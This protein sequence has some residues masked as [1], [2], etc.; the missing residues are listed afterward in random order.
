[1]NAECDRPS[2]GHLIIVC[3]ADIFALVLHSHP[4]QD[5]Y[6]V[7]VGHDGALWDV[8]VLPG[9]VV[10]G[11]GV[12][13]GDA[14]KPHV[15]A[16]HGGLREGL[17]E[18]LG[19]PELLVVGVRG[20]LELE[21]GAVPA[22]VGNRALDGATVVALVDLLEGGEVD[23][24]VV[25]DHD[26]TVLIDEVGKV[27]PGPVELDVGEVLG[28]VARNGLA[29]IFRADLFAPPKNEL[30]NEAEGDGYGPRP[31]GAEFIRSGAEVLAPVGHLVRIVD[32]QLA[33]ANSDSFIFERVNFIR[34]KSIILESLLEPPVSRGGPSGGDAE[35]AYVVDHL[36][37]AHVEHGLIGLPDEEGSHGVEPGVSNGLAVLMST[38]VCHEVSNLLDGHL[39]DE[40][41][42]LV[43]EDGLEAPPLLL[44]AIR[45]HQVVLLVVREAVLS[46]LVGL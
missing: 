21:E 38:L 6:P 18:V 20:D 25:R 3:S 42:L 28:R 8:R 11:H 2:D 12:A 17:G 15:L 44:V 7:V 31:D 5:Q 37:P 14:L 39:A 29:P 45:V 36:P 9:P 43:P 30:A 35:Q 34:D 41:V 13:E 16:G 4:G 10:V 19:E 24:A 32:D 22:V 33:A 46:P 23:V 26:P 1:M 27:V 40:Q